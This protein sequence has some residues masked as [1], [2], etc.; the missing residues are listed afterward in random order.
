M[1]AANGPV[2]DTTRV[3]FIDRNWTVVAD[4]V[5]EFAASVQGTGIEVLFLT[6]RDP[7]SVVGNLE[8]I[9]L[10]D[11]PQQR[12]LEELQAVY[13]FSLHKTL[14]PERAYY[15]YSSFRRSQCYSR[16]DERQIAAAVTPFAN[17]MDYLIRE[18]ADLV[19]EWYPDCFIPSM[20]GQIAAYYGKPFRMFLQHY[21]WSNGAFFIDR[22]NLTSSDV[23]ARYRHARENPSLCDRAYLDDVFRTKKTLYGFS[24]S[25]M[26]TLASGSA[27][28]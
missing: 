2:G 3:L 9:N 6:D 15:D 12:S 8:T 18:R 25:E 7:S 19:M 28:S 21:W 13:P 23:D 17:A 1:I 14:V 4:L 5:R 24:A 22:L 11:V 20:A 26:Y 27:W 16:L 10:R